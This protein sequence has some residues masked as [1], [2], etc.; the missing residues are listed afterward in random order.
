MVTE[1]TLHWRYI[2]RGTQLFLLNRNWFFFPIE[3]A[4]VWLCLFARKMLGM[5]QTDEQKAQ[6]DK[7][8]EMFYGFKVVITQT[9]TGKTLLTQCFLYLIKQNCIHEYKV[10]TESLRRHT[11]K[12][13]SCVIG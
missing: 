8:R 2:P 6:E 1:S 13:K 5:E 3:R 4:D 10:G 7:E 11:S 9:M 12:Y